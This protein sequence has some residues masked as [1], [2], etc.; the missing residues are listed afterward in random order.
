MWVLGKT[1]LLCSQAEVWVAFILFSKYKKQYLRALFLMLIS[2]LVNANLKVIFKMPLPEWLH[3]AGYAFPSGHMQVAVVFWGWL[4]YEFASLRNLLAG[5]VLL[6]GVGYWIVFFK[7]HSVFDI[8]GAV[9]VGLAIVACYAYLIKKYSWLT[10]LHSAQIFLMLSIPLAI[11]LVPTIYYENVML[12]Q[13]VLLGF[14]VA[15]VFYHNDDYEQ[16]YYKG[17][18]LC[19]ALVV[20]A[21]GLGL[22]YGVLTLLSVK[23][24]SI[25]HRFPIAFLGSVWLSCGVDWI[26]QR[27]LP[28]FKS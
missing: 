22:G 27:V 24:T 18:Q 8:C 5:T 17:K 6:A 21:V 4:M 15:G 12:V 14:Y 2:M 9:P 3:S 7:Y 25:E 16:H 13:G 20:A 23:A 19:T 26:V 28:R 1:W 10:L 11:Q